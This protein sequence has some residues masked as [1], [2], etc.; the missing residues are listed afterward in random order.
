MDNFSPKG[1]LNNIA[2]AKAEYPDDMDKSLEHFSIYLRSRDNNYLPDIFGKFRL[3]LKGNDINGSL[4]VY[5][6]A[7]QKEL[8][9][10]KSLESPLKNLKS[11]F[12]QFKNKYKVELSDKLDKAEE[13]E[14]IELQNYL[15]K[16]NATG[17]E[18]I[19]K[20]IKFYYKCTLSDI[21]NYKKLADYTRTEL[22]KLYLKSEIKSALE[23]EPNLDKI[24]EFHSL[25]QQYLDDED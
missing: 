22:P 8:N 13:K 10:L 19:S 9:E 7:S 25:K 16:V 21:A 11:I 2:V 5:L 3:N 15:L 23:E 4:E 17:I 20:L 12:E 24:P 18:N 1:V 14:K 6:K